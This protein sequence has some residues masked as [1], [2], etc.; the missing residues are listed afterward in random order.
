MYY[1]GLL[2]YL[3]TGRKTK[4]HPTLFCP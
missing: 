4:V 2:G 3:I 1:P